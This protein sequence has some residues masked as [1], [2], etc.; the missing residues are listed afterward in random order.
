[1]GLLRKIWTRWKAFGRVLVRVQT[2]ILLS[3]VYHVSIGPLGLLCRLLKR[4]LLGLHAVAGASFAVEL[5]RIS[6]TMEQAQKQF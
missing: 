1:M 5:P 3:I 4:D 6:T 2:L